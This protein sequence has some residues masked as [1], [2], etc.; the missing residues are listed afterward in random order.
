VSALERLDAID[1]RAMAATPGPW[2]IQPDLH[3]DD[4]DAYVGYYPDPD[5]VE[6]EVFD[7]RY[8]PFMGIELRF[9]R[10]REFIEYS[11]QDVPVMATALR[12]LLHLHA[13]VVRGGPAI[14]AGCSD[15]LVSFLW[16]CATVRVIETELAQ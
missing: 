3:S 2:S 13:R 12:A 1:A 7:R 8:E 14:C 9:D 6:V 10:D 16:P 4:A 5:D 11:R 15:D